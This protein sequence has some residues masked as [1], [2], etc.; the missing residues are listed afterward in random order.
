MNSFYEDNSKL[1]ALAENLS[2]IQKYATS[3]NLNIK[4]VLM[5]YAYQI[6]K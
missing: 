3:N 2:Y 5:P 1:D 6:Q 4:F